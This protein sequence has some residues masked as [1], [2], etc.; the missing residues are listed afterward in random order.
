MHLLRCLWFFV[1]FFDIC[2]SAEHIAGVTNC[3]ADMLSRNNV[4]NFLLIR[5][6]HTV[7]ST[8]LHLTHQIGH[9]T[10]S[11]VY[12]AVLCTWCSPKHMEYL[13]CRPAVHLHQSTM[14]GTA[15]L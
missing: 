8:S 15:Y 14:G 12:S 3:V 6:R 2:I 7:Y 13:L 4:T 5:P 11:A 1:A 10:P 9:P